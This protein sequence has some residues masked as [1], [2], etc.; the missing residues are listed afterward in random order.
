M[1]IYTEEYNIQRAHTVADLLKSGA[2]NI[3]L[4]VLSTLQE[5]LQLK[6]ES[7]GL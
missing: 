6:V 7:M 5:A 2:V 3:D 1:L 4:R